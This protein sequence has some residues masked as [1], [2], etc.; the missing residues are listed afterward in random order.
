L[1]R[2]RERDARRPVSALRE[3]FAGELM[4][5]ESHDYEAMAAK[6]RHLAEEV[7]S[8]YCRDQLLRIAEG[9]DRLARHAEKWPSPAG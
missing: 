3:L 7:K 4:G 2:D 5:H 9:F 8:D 6:L 1:L